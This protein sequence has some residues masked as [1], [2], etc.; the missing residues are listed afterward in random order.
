MASLHRIAIEALTNARRHANGATAVD[1]TVACAPQ[2]VVLSVT[3]D[4]VVVTERR[5]GFGLVGI[6]ERVAALGGRFEAG[7][8]PTGGWSVTAVIPTSPLH[9]RS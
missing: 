2:H 5:Q 3:N 1:V 4:G 7:P 9:N 6:A 8:R